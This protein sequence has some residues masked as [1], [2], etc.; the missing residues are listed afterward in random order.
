[1]SNSDMTIKYL[2][3]L[4]TSEVDSVEAQHYYK[5]YREE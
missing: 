3:R 2:A 1:M 4:L 5:S